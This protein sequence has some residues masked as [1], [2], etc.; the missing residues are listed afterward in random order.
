MFC[1]PILSTRQLD[2]TCN[3]CTGMVGMNF[4]SLPHL[5]FDAESVDKLSIIQMSCAFSH[6]MTSAPS[7]H[8]RTSGRRRAGDGRTVRHS[9]DK[10][11]VPAI[12]KRMNYVDRGRAKSG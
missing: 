9:I 12:I 1:D 6:V 2:N 7:E 5:W 8:T 3:V 10:G 4:T 11:H